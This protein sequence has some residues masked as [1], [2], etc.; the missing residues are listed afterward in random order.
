MSGPD[1]PG[2]ITS[3]LGDR[4]RGAL[5]V[6][7]EPDIVAF[8]GA[9]F[10]ASGLRLEHIDPTTAA[11]VVSAAI[12]LRIGCVLLDMGLRGTNGF[13]VLTAL[14]AEPRLAGLPVIIVSANDSMD[15][16]RRA[17]ALGAD[18]FVAKPFQVRKLFA[19]VADLVEPEES[20]YVS[21]ESLAGHLDAVIGRAG[22]K[23][24][25]LAL[26]RITDVEGADLPR[27]ALPDVE[28]RLRSTLVNAE[29]VGW[30][31]PAEV[32]VTFEAPSDTAAAEVSQ[33]RHQ[34]DDVVIT[35]GLASHPSAGSTADQLYMAADA[36]LTE[37]LEAGAGLATSR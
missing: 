2:S 1:R 20:R 9:F 18:D 34:W 25:V 15:V 8:L 35:A 37:A 33:I 4:A 14:R 16:R 36:A 3:R 10:R 21:Q 28:A 27:F 19:Q 13:E 26:L 11:E 12:E 24:S 30:T 31:G 22:S 17:A 29:V 5:V 6:E 32:A 7:D 23:Q